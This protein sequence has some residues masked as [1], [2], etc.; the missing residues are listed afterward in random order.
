MFKEKKKSLGERVG[1]IPEKLIYSPI[2]LLFKSV[3]NIQ[4]ASER[5]GFCMEKRDYEHI[6]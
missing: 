5:E 2:N 4:M 6:F 1:G 3:A